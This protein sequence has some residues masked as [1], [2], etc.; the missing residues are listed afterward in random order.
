MILHD[1]CEEPPRGVCVIDPTSQLINT[2]IGYIPKSRKNDLIYFDTSM[3]IPIDFFS[4]R[5]SEKNDVISDL[6]NIIDLATSPAAKEYLANALMVF[7]AWNKKTTEPIDRLTIFDVPRF[8]QD[9][10]FRKPILAR[11]PPDLAYYF[12]PHIRYNNE[13]LSALINRMSKIARYDELKAILGAKNPQLNIGR[14]IDE[15]NKILLVKLKENSEPD[16]IVGSII[17]AK[18]QHAIFARQDLPDIYSCTPYYLYIDECDTMLKFAEERFVSIL[19]RA[20]KCKLCMT[21]ACPEPGD[22]PDGIQKGL[23]KIG[24]LV[25]FNL[26]KSQARIFE[27][28]LLPYKPDVLVGLAPFHAFLRTNNQLHG[29]K[30][31]AFL[32]ILQNNHAQYAKHNTL[33]EYGPDACKTEDKS[34]TSGNGEAPKTV[35]QDD[36][37]KARGTN[38]PGRVL[39]PH[40][41][42]TRAAKPKPDPD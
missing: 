2:I 19:K 28:R 25:L 15:G 34:H 23:G 27:D 37:G 39:R 31:P 35:L 38:P 24:N 4:A 41:Q 10:E 18:I 12:P 26:A 30:T 20:R 11:C 40:N 17:A 21:I 6:V 14:I 29:I 8:I 3:Q 42:P 36:A 16:A 33:R 32:P 5:E 13:S 22:L 1:I 9:E 7:F